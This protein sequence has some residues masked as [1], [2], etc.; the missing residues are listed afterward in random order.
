MKHFIRSFC[1]FLLYLTILLWGSKSLAQVDI[2]SYVFSTQNNASLYDETGAINIIGANADNETS[3]NILLPFRFGFAGDVHNYFSASSNGRIILSGTNFTNSYALYPFYVQG[4]S[5][6]TLNASG[7][8]TSAT[9]SVYFKI[10]GTVPNRKVVIGFKNMSISR[11]GGEN[12]ASFQTILHESTGVIEFIYGKMETA[13]A[14]GFSNN[15]FRPG[16]GRTNINRYQFVNTSTHTVTQTT[17]VNTN[18]FAPGVIAN[19]NAAGAGQSRLYRFTPPQVQQFSNTQIMFSGT[20]SGG[21]NFT[22]NHPQNGAIS[23]LLSDSIPG[24]ISFGSSSLIGGGFAQHNRGNA[25]P[26]VR[27]YLR[28]YASNGGSIST[29]FAEGSYQPLPP[30]VFTSQKNGSWNDNTVWGKVP[31]VLPGPGDSVVV[32]NVDTIA[33]NSIA[34]CGA[35]HINGVVDFALNG[36]QLIVTRNLS[37]GAGAVLNANDKRFMGA[38]V[39]QTTGKPVQVLGS[40]IGSGSMDFSFSGARLQIEEGV[41]F[42]SEHRI[43][44]P[45]TPVNGKP[46]LRNLLISTRKPIQVLTPIN[47]VERIDA[48]KGTIVT[49][50]NVTLDH[51]FSPTPFTPSVI[52]I[53]RFAREPLFDGAVVHG[54]GADYNINLNYTRNRN[55]VVPN[56]D[57]VPAQFIAGPEV[58]P[59]GILNRMLLGSYRGVLFNQPLTMKDELDL[60]GN[61]YLGN[62]E[63]RFVN[64]SRIFYNEGGITT[65]AAIVSETGQRFFPIKYQGLNRFIQTNLSAGSFGTVSV[66]YVHAE[67][68]TDFASPYT[69]AGL[70]FTTR[71]NFY[72]QV[73]NN[74]DNGNAGLLNSS[75][76]LRAGNFPRIAD[77]TKFGISRANGAAPGMHQTATLGNGEMQC[78]RDGFSYLDVSGN[79]Y[80]AFEKSSALPVTLLNFTATKQGST[81]HLQ[82][83]TVNEVNNRG[84]AIESSVNGNRFKQIGFVNAIAGGNLAS[85]NEYS[86]TDLS[87]ATGVNY[88]RLQQQDIDGRFSYSLVRKLV[89]DAN[90]QALKVYPTAAT[91]SVVLQNIQQVPGVK[92]TLRLLS[93]NGV[94]LREF[95]SSGTTL[96]LDIESLPAGSYFI[97]A[98]NGKGLQQARFIKL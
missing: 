71:S 63:L 98:T 29:N 14:L 97:T 28:V 79:F 30:Q 48:D 2:N 1:A 3:D 88:Y 74:Y 72:W 66:K 10:T 94:V 78:N 18:N 23:F 85:K 25:Y 52:Q 46:L 12:N 44:T 76:L 11:A 24:I 69:E 22:F 40:I 68:N 53:F 5:S 82:W 42:F 81:A 95:F 20:A 91:H 80:I 58:P 89:F 17:S 87:P 26:G 21:T 19:L 33:I 77:Y 57:L 16:I 35:L 45:L 84:F 31:G 6:S 73:I 43:E 56:D 55:R 60:R 83:K 92:T 54:T 9:G 36:L 13:V 90:L 59:N 96:R 61:L 86:F 65:S 7:M 47:I 75:L 51:R 34:Q 49:N 8:G 4:N 27:Y 15:S 37:F 93:A 38:N 67:G 41:G 62:N 32:R 64:S 70:N 39:N 50:N